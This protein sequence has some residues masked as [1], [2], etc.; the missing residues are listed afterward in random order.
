MR[1]PTSILNL[2][3]IEFLFTDDKLTSM[4]KA[5]DKN[6]KAVG[7]ELSCKFLRRDEGDK[8]KS[9]YIVQFIY[10]TKNNYKEDSDDLRVIVTVKDSNPVEFKIED[11]KPY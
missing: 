6:E 9:I 1:K 8:K 3:I 7:T 5:R 11:I 10:K 2:K 4:L